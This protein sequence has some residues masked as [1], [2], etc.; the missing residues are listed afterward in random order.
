MIRTLKIDGRTGMFDIPSFLLSENEHLTI[1]IVITG[2][3]YV[4]KYRLIVKHGDDKRTIALKNFPEITLPAE[5]LNTS[6]ENLEFSLVFLD[7]DETRVIKD[8]YNIEPLKLE[9]VDGNFAFTAKVQ[10]LEAR[11]AEFEKALAA[12]KAKLTEF[13]GQGIALIPEDDNQE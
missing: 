4:G 7:M 8:D 5:W 2:E 9:R 11:Q 13:D 3:I 6:A 12:F 10:A 1:R